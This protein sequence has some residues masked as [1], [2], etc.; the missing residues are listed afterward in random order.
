[1]QQRQQIKRFIL[2]NFLFSD[3]PSA[4][5]DQDSLIRGGII[6]S[7]GI[8]ELIFFLEDQFKLQIVPEE[9]TPA[10]FDSIQTVDEFVSRKLAG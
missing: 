6:D 8:H 3:D 2:E 1:M 5:G 10:N 4:I 7:T 9:M